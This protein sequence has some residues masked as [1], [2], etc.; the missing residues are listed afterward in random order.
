MDDSDPEGFEAAA[1]QSAGDPR[2]LIALNVTLST[3]FAVTIA[4]G[5]GF[6]DLLEFNVVNTA[7]IAILLFTATYAITR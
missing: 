7:T 3:M 4:W 1:E 2:V 6:V 5:M